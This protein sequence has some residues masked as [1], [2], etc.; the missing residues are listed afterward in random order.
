MTQSI[1]KTAAHMRSQV[2]DVFRSFI[3][4]FSVLKVAYYSGH[5]VNNAISD[6]PLD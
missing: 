4:V 1:M 2:A 3:E 5:E 6:V